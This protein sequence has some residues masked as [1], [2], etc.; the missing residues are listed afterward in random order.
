MFSW[1]WYFIDKTFLKWN[2]VHEIVVFQQESLSIYELYSH[3][4]YFWV[5]YN[6]IVCIDLLD[7]RQTMVQIV[8]EVTKRDQF[9]MKLWSHFEGIGT[10]LMNKAIVSSLGECLNEFIREEQC[11]LTQGTMEQKKYVIIPVS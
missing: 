9:L 1:Y 8:D 4:M 3:F 10:K 6:D 11:F 7:E 2:F 5:E